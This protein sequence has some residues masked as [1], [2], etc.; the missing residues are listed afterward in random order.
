MKKV[1][2][3]NDRIIQAVFTATPENKFWALAILEGKTE[4][5]TQSPH[6]TDSPLL[7]SMGDGAKLLG[8]SRC[9]LWRMIREGRLEK[10]E[11]YHN[12]YRLRRSD[13]LDLVNRKAVRHG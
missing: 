4:L 7:M 2:V 6:S 11:I 5:P 3:T 1:T 12:S 10:V 8:I 13:L 9:T